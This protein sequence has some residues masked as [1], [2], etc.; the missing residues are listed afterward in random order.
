MRENEQGLHLN[1]T[2]LFIRDLN[3]CPPS[4]LNDPG[5]AAF[6]EIVWLQDENPIHQLEPGQQPVKG[7]WIYLIPPYRAHQLNKSG[8]K[9]FLLSFK[10][11]LLEEE[12]K[13]FSLDVFKMFNFQ[14]D[15][16]SIHID[17]TAAA[18][19]KKVFLLLQEEYQRAESNFLILRS[20]LKVFLLTLIRIK[21]QAFTPQD[22]NHKRVY[23]FFLLL[24]SNYQTIRHTDF[25]AGQLGLSTKR[26]NQILK[27]SL[28]KTSM[29]LIHDR[30]ILEAKRKI[31]HNERTIKEIAYFLGFKDRP[32]FS[33]FFKIQTGQTPEEFQ[34]LARKH[35]DANG[36]TLIDGQDFNLIH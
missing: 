34:K 12:E 27:E 11:D 14:G 1:E 5:R 7:D 20:L 23:E 33:R 36:N 24:E 6:F 28:D 10:R 31:V 4:Y 30:L 21:E 35:I 26:L 13:E 8:K 15:Y 2:L 9:G 32:Y 29:Q 16:S 25:Y 3:N 22:I 17:T 19:L 18:Q